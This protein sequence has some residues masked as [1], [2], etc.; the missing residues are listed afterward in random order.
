[1]SVWESVGICRDWETEFYRA[2]S[3]AVLPWKVS[4]WRDA[5]SPEGWVSVGETWHFSFCPELRG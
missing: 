3:R 1:M 4:P 2:C 5:H